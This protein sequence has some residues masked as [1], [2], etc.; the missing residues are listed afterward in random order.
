M[1]TRQHITDLAASTATYSD[2][3]AYRY[4]LTR[5]WDQS[6]PR[7]LFVMLNPSTATELHNDPTVERCERRARALG[8]GAFRVTN[9]FAWRDTDPRAL[10]RAADPIG[11]ANDASLLAAAVWA[12]QIIAAW[13]THGVHL[14][15]G[16][17]VAE[18]LRQTG[19]PLLTLGLT[20]DGH[21]RH[22]LYVSYDQHPRGWSVP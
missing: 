10:R 19:T 6:A 15:R 17:Q 8:F 5:I 20:K 7:L 22:P 9:I 13:G 3:D 11:P 14:G 16:A 21:P 2:C 18:L 4:D 1:I 12:D